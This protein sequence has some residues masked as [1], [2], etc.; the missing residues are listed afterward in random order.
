MERAGTNAGLR[1]GFGWS[2]AVSAGV[3]FALLVGYQRHLA[4]EAVRRARVVE[5]E[6]ALERDGKIAEVARAVSAMKLVSVE[7]ETRVAL[8]IVDES[9]RGD[10]RV[11]V[12]APARLLYGVDLSRASASR[13]EWG[14]GDACVVRIPPAE[15]IATEVYNERER[16]DVRVGWL[17][18]R[19]R[20]GEY[21]LGEARRLLALRAR[22]MELGEEDARRVSEET[23]GRVAEVVRRILG[24]RASV[25]VIED[26]ALAG[27]GP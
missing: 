23:R 6:A 19:S 26:G 20:A 10:V 9:W 3:L 7:I 18:L 5:R 8:D 12:E 27:G 21:L 4:G 2:L 11:G 22:E 1:G 16:V 13:V 15:R 14:A 17:R 25:V 24:E